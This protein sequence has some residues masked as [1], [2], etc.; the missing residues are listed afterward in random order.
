[1]RVNWA[2]GTVVGL[3]LWALGGPAAAQPSPPKSPAPAAKPAPAAAQPAP[4]AATPAPAAATPAPAAPPAAKPAP[5]APAP[6]AATPAAL[7]APTP[8]RLLKAGRLGKAA[9]G[10]R[11]LVVVD[12]PAKP[13]A[14]AAPPGS[15]EALLASSES[16]GDLARTLEPYTELCNEELDMTRR[17]CEVVRTYL[18]GVLAKRVFNGEAEAGALVV[19]PYAAKQGGRSLTLR[20]C[21][22]CAQP[23][24]GDRRHLV[25]VRPPQKIGGAE[26]KGLDVTSVK[27]PH[28]SAHVADIWQRDVGSKL[29]TELVYKLGPAWTQKVA[30]AKAPR[31]G[32]APALPAFDD[33]SGEVRGLGLQLLGYRVYSRCSGAVL[34]SSPKSAFPVP[35]EPAADCPKPEVKVAS[36]QPLGRQPDPRWPYVLS[37]G[38]IRKTFDGIRGQVQACYLQFQ[39]PGQAE[40]EVEIGGLDGNVLAVKVSGLFEDT[41]TADCIAAA[42]SVARF[43]NFRAK[44]MKVPY[45]FF[46]R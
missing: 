14:P 18:R 22:A 35:V 40:L 4:A 28:A 17:Q 11:R 41:P 37:V 23:V 42:L 44:S 31:K 8:K 29:R 24:S 9:R 6:A 26:L 43:P 46:L 38:D 5:T 34:A 16:I 19:G 10:Q 45:N 33:G 25:T 20:G 39:I 15:F 13:K 21:V 2:R 1:M 12:A 3:A 27:V 32:P 7:T 30:K 36:S